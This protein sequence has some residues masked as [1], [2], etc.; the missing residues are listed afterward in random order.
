MSTYNRPV[1]CV[2]QESQLLPT[3]RH[4]NRVRLF[5]FQP[6]C[7]GVSTRSMFSKQNTAVQYKRR[8]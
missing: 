4:T 3:D 6:R 2:S 1:L 8:I 7:L 5:G